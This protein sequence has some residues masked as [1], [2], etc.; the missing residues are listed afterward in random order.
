MRAMAFS[1][2]VSSP[3]ALHQ[4]L[5]AEPG[6]RSDPRQGTD[7]DCPHTG[8]GGPMQ[9]AP[10]ACPV[11]S[12]NWMIS[13]AGHAASPVMRLSREPER[14]TMAGVNLGRRFAVA[15]TDA[16]VPLG[17]GMPIT[18]APVHEC[19][20]RQKVICRSSE[21]CADAGRFSRFNEGALAKCRSCPAAGCG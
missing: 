3:P 18:D 21:S 16:G 20:A 4:A 11:A 19:I 12:N 6:H 1:G 7:A 15:L 9:Q 10:M 17:R 2:C 13:G 14:S 5:L 8:T